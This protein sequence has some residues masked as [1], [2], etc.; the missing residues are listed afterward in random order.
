MTTTSRGRVLV[1]ADELQRAEA[2]ATALRSQGF[3]AS[4][5]LPSTALDRQKEE[6]VDVALCHL[7][8]I[9]LDLT[10]RLA[11]AGLP[12]ILTAQSASVELA[13]AALRSGARDLVSE[14]IDEVVLAQTLERLCRQR[15][16]RTRLPHPH[17]VGDSTSMRRV[18]ALVSRVA[19]GDAPVLLCGESGTGKELAAHAI[20]AEGPRRHAPFIVVNCA[21]VPGPLLESELFG[22]ARGAYTDAR[23]ERKGLFLQ[24]EGGTLFLDEI[25]ELP[26]EL[27]PKLLRAL[28]ER[29]VRPLGG[30]GEI[31]FDARLITATN[32]DLEGAVRDRHFREDLY[33]RVNVVRIDLPPLRE[34]QGDVLPLAQHFLEHIAHRH[35]RPVARLSEAAADRLLS[36]DWPGNVR[37]LENCIESALALARFED[38]IGV[39]DLP[40]RI[41]GAVTPTDLAL[42]SARADQLVTLEELNR[43]YLHRV[44]RALNGNKS[45]AAEVLGVDR[46]TLYRMLARE[47][48]TPAP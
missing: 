48:R 18:A 14:P 4:A 31:A 9:D 37:E 2:R 7:D 13:V 43:R 19:N 10:R 35:G 21:A 47:V 40:A 28:Q 27:Q 23:A 41:R 33:Y 20:H 26:L 39:D 15:G 30:N 3:T 46:R 22:H 24:A 8:G 5:S 44:M 1:V 42:P 45:R 36:Y 6:D 11:E 12:V 25:G 29:K 32:R 38:E 34:R 17:R 16:G